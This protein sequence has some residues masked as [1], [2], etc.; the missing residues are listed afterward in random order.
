MGEKRFF[1]LLGAAGDLRL[2]FKIRTEKGRVVGILVQLEMNL[3]GCWKPVTRYDNSHDFPHRDML[4]PKGTEVEKTP[5]K[6][7][8]L[9]EVLEYAEQDLTDRADWYAKRFLGM[10]GH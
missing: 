8:S 6:L 5:L 3:A 10:R 2:R 4:D 1:K 7:S 9:D